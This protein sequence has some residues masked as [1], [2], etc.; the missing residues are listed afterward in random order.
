[1]KQRRQGHVDERDGAAA[2]AARPRAG[3]RDEA[4]KAR[5]WDRIAERYARKPVADEKAYQEKLRITREWLAPEAE[6]VELGC[7]TGSTAIAHAPHVRRIRAVDVSDGML[8]I[9][10]RKATAAG[11][12]NVVFERASV[13]NFQA[14]E[15]AWTRC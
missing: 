4:R 9:A 14:P 8:E 1:M 13:E 6:I 3:G 2:S 5:F 15:G 7:G 10:R 12:E 11:V